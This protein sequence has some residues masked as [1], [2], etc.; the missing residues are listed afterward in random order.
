MKIQEELPLP[1]N[2]LADLATDYHHAVLHHAWNWQRS[3]D[4]VTLLF[5]FVELL[6]AENPASHR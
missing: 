6:P 5:A 2:P 1:V 4:T 3:S